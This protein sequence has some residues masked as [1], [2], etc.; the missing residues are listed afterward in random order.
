MYF[1]YHKP[2]YEVFL[3]ENSVHILSFKRSVRESSLLRGTEFVF[4]A[5]VVTGGGEAEEKGLCEEFA[6]L[7]L[8]R[9]SKNTNSKTPQCDAWNLPQNL[10]SLPD[11]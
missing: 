10:S 2:K 3:A 7:G 9:L 11:K 1:P 5:Q 6:S 4:C 8:W